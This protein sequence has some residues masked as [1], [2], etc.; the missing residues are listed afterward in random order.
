MAMSPLA[1]RL[2]DKTRMDL[3]DFRDEV[4]QW[5]LANVEAHNFYSGTLM[6]VFGQKCRHH[7]EGKV[8][9]YFEWIE[10]EAPAVSPASLRYESLE[11]CV[12]TIV[13]YRQQVRT[14]AMELNGRWQG[15]AGMVDLGQLD[16]VNDKFIVDRGEKLS[17]ALGLGSG[18]RWTERLNHLYKDNPWFFHT[19]SVV[20]FIISIAAFVRSG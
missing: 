2:Y 17:S 9:E 19:L 20:A 8:A 3:R 13:T 10:K 1:Q 16:G 4:V 5:H 11:Q 6:D 14:M 12:G 7:L 18:A 15:L